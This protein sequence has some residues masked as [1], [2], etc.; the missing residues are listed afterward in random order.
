V[1]VGLAAGQLG[2]IRSRL[3]GFGGV[4]SSQAVVGVEERCHSG[5]TWDKSWECNSVVLDS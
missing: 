5:T 3:W 4:E 1:N 2:T